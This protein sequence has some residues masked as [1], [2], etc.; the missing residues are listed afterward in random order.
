MVVKS[1]GFLHCKIPSVRLNS[2]IVAVL[3]VLV[4]ISFASDAH[5]QTNLQ[6]KR[7]DDTLDKYCREN[8]RSVP[9][10]CPEY[11]PEGHGLHQEYDKSAP[12]T[13][14]PRLDYTM[15][16]SNPVTSSKIEPTTSASNDFGNIAGVIMGIVFLA[17]ATKVTVTVLKNHKP[18]GAIY[19]TSQSY[20]RMGYCSSLI[21]LSSSFFHFLKVGAVWL[22]QQQQGRY[23]PQ[24]QGRQQQGRQ[25]QEQQRGRDDCPNSE[26]I[27]IQEAYDLLEV[28][29]QSTSDE[30]K[31]SRR[32][33][34]LQWHPDKHK[35]PERKKIAENQMKLIN[36]AFDVLDKELNIR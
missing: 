22:Y 1:R 20:S 9:D 17:V 19:G 18:S 5:A 27:T 6:N 10:M 8:W 4:F 23:R 34:T 15:S 31:Q 24:Q 26:Q 21:R 32:R 2:A 3:A 33:L 36:E 14:S 25:Q 16:S 28:T 7:L 30:I 12:T 11:I 13:Y 29:K 35:T